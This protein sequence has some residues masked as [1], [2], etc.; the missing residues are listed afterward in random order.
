MIIADT[1]CD[2]MCM[3]T[4]YATWLHDMF[5]IHFKKKDHQIWL[6]CCC[7]LALSLS[8]QF[9]SGEWLGK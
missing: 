4:E 7:P 2:V 3:L 1:S 6:I 5:V 8:L 9:P